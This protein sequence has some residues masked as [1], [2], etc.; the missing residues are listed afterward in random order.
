[1]TIALTPEMEQ[2]IQRQ[3]A[4]G[5]YA[6]PGEVLWEALRE[7]ERAPQTYPA[8]ADAP[9]SEDAAVPPRTRTVLEILAEMPPPGVFKTSAE[10]DAYLR[11]ER[12]A[13]DR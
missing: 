4:Q 11:E 9:A 5:R 3:I 1:M 12:D 8:A 6:S 10:A 7:L 2:I 13:W